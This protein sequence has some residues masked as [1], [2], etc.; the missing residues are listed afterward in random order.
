VIVEFPPVETADSETGLLAFGGD[1]AVSS[2]EM[3]YRSGIFPWPTEN[4]PILWFAPPERAIIEFSEFNIPSRL[5]RSLKK[6][7]FTFRVNSNFAEVIKNCANLTNRKNQ[8]GTWI[9]DEMISAYI[10]FHKAGFALSFE[11]SNKND[12]LV[13]GLYG[14][15]INKYFAGESM[16]YKETNASK[17]AL[18]QT[19]QYLKTLE[20]S[21]ID[22]QILNPF[23]A[24]FGANEISRDL[25]MQ[26]LNQALNDPHE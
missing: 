24:T 7:P 6:S 8:Q 1:L 16:F 11:V 10:E 20:I 17:F 5:E 9:T 3:A 14:V 13:G 21:W 4:Q 18:I 12:K 23:L 15:L 25:F 26:K 19:V 2:L 22:V